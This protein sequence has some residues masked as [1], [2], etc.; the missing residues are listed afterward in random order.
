MVWD[1]GN[2][3]PKSGNNT[4]TK[5]FSCFDLKNLFL[6]KNRSNGSPKRNKFM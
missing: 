5:K 3:T 2:G 1:K 6:A 4:P